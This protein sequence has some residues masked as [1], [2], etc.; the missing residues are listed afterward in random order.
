MIEPVQVARHIVVPFASALQ[1][2][3]QQQHAAEHA[4]IVYISSTCAGGSSSDDSM[5][6]RTEGWALRINNWSRREAAAMEYCSCC[7]HCQCCHASQQH[8]QQKREF[9][10]LQHGNSSNNSNRNNNVRVTIQASLACPRSPSCRKTCVIPFS[11]PVG[12]C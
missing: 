7:H 2:Q 10:Y 5:K 12:W 3:Q 1:Q 6:A 4:S 11:P 8:L 9:Y